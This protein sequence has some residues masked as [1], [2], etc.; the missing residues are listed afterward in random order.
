MYQS[1]FTDKKILVEE[2]INRSSESTVKTNVE[3]KTKQRMKRDSAF[4]SACFCLT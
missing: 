4:A 2:E 1:K 3:N